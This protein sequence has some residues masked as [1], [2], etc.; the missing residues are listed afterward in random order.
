[1]SRPVPPVWR[2]QPILVAA[3]LVCAAS[4]LILGFWAFSA[5]ESFSRFIDY[6]PYNQH[7]IHDAG[8]F[9]IGIGAALLL[10]LVCPDALLM[11]LTGVHGRHRP[12]RHLAL[13]RPAHR[14]PRQ[15]RADAQPAHACRA[16][17]HLCTHPQ[18]EGMKILL[19]GASGAIGTPLVPPAHLPWS[20][21]ARADPCPLWR[22]P[23]RRR[24]R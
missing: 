14:R 19:A 12:A 6:A 17:R 7:L 13:H 18:E 1:M 15:R 22:R 21:G 11:A 23:D 3:T 9:Q 5:P 8:A 20:S 4:M 24:R 2:R 16:V 10:A